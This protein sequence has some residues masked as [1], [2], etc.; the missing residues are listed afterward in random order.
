MD[1][2]VGKKKAPCRPRDVTEVVEERK[3]RLPVK[4]KVGSKTD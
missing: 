2:S 1:R 4:K 3:P